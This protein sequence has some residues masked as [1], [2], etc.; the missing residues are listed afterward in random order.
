MTS[1]LRTFE[2]SCLAPSHPLLASRR[3][4]CLAVLLDSTTFSVASIASGK[5]LLPGRLVFIETED[6]IA[7]EAG[8]AFIAL[9]ATAGHRFPSHRHLANVLYTLV[10]EAVSMGYP[11]G[12]KSL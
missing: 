5:R 7:D 12:S 11:A 1:C 10:P 3:A 9:S 6:G 8:G 2:T 4:D